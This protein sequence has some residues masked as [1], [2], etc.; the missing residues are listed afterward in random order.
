[1]K[2]TTLVFI[3]QVQSTAKLQVLQRGTRPYITERTRARQLNARY[4]KANIFLSELAEKSGAEQAF[5]K[6]HGTVQALLGMAS[7]L[8]HCKD[9]LVTGDPCLNRSM[10]SLGRVL[11]GS[12]AAM[13]K[14]KTIT[15]TVSEGE[16]GTAKQ[17]ETRDASASTCVSKAGNKNELVEGIVSSSR[18]PWS[19][20]YQSIHHDKCIQLSKRGSRSI[21][22]GMQAKHEKSARG[23][24][25]SAEIMKS[26]SYQRQH[27]SER[28]GLRH[29]RKIK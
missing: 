6:S 9:W 3:F 16:P 26:G 21:R 14:D 10:F 8:L 24:S 18:Q 13:P 29:M 28:G 27:Y 12:V 25:P 4:A 17:D 1:M 19:M 15:T 22:T 5:V 23:G 7:Q 20:I 2:D 11:T